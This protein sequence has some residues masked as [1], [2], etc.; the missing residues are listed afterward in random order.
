MGARKLDS[1]RFKNFSPKAQE[2]IAGLEREKE[3]REDEEKAP[4]AEGHAYPSP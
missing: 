3:H 1:K 2:R 4:W